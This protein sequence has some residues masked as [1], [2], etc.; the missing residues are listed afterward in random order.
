MAVLTT[1]GCGVLRQKLISCSSIDIDDVY[2][3]GELDKVEGHH[4]GFM[5]NP[6]THR[7]VI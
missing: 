3:F 2:C 7:A 1:D 5:D 4:I 6:R